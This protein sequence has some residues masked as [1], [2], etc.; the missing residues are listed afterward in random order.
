VFSKEK[1]LRLNRPAG[2][3]SVS[4]TGRIDDFKAEDTKPKSPSGS[5]VY[6]GESTIDE[7][8]GLPDVSM[9]Q[10][11]GR[12][13]SL[14]HFM[15]KNALSNGFDI[16]VSPGRPPK[17]PTIQPKPSPPIPQNSTESRTHRPRA[18]TLDLGIVNHRVRK[19]SLKG[20]PVL[21]SSMITEDPVSRLPDVSPP[22]SSLLPGSS[23][24]LRQAKAGRGRNRESLDL[25]EIM[26][27]DDDLEDGSASGDNDQSTKPSPAFSPP[28]KVH[29]Q[30]KSATTN[31]PSTTREILHFLDQGWLTIVIF[32]PF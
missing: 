8:R 1:N 31:G 21:D 14:A 6:G 22:S 18:S 15:G 30:L 16:P 5:R 13:V 23:P 2:S 3:S 26:D 7:G 29:L 28:P 17:A 12:T 25:D 24:K 10:P 19:M 11:R 9:Q 32:L 27:G 4:L 20:S